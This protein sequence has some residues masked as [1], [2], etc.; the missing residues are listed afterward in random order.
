MLGCSS[1]KLETVPRQWTRPLC[2]WYTHL[3][4][5]RHWTAPDASDI[6]HS[7]YMWII[8][9]F[10]F[11]YI[12]EIYVQP[13]LLYNAW[14][15]ILAVVLFKIST[16]RRMVE[17]YIHL[18]LLVELKFKWIHGSRS[19]TET[20]ILFTCTYKY[21]LKLQALKLGRHWISSLYCRNHSWIDRLSFT[22]MVWT[23]RSEDPTTHTTQTVTR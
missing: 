12:F 8:F 20:S 22:H 17:I 1:L 23:L 4:H 10:E 15:G 3:K 9:N 14:C 18:I 21:N 6:Q 11:V 19:W 13:V 5:V 16:I 7:C 2:R